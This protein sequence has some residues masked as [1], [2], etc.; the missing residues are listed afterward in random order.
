MNDHSQQDTNRTETYTKT[1]AMEALNKE[2]E[3]RKRLEKALEKERAL[4]HTLIDTLPDHIYVKDSGS[5]F[6]LA[7]DAIV[8]SMAVSTQDEL[9]GKTDFDFHPLEMAEQYYADEQTIL[10]SGQPLINREEPVIDQQTG[11]IRWLLSTKVPFRDGQGNIAGLVGINRDITKRKQAEEALQKL[12]EKLEQ[13]VKDRTAELDALQHLMDQVTNIAEQLGDTSEE[14]TRISAQMAIGSQQTS[15][16][17]SVV[18]SSSQRISQYVGEV[19]VAAEELAASIQEISRAITDVTK[20][21]ANAGS[22]A[23]TAN[24]TISSLK[25]N[26][27]EIGGIIQVITNIAKQTN[28]LALNATLEAARAGDLGKGFRVVADEVRE[29]SEETSISA[30]DIAHKI[31]II[32]T[33]SQEATEAITEV[34]NII[35]RVSELSHTVAAAISEQTQTTSEISRTIAEAAQGSDNISSAISKVTPVAQ[36]SSEQ[37]VSVRDEAQEL[38]SL[39]EQL[40]QLVKGFQV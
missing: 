39:A 9:L 17:V 21:I 20:I 33:G 22:I 36:D 29:L 6:L 19:S 25:T 3:E 4:L 30:K 35:S 32:Q 23:D 24:T 16:Q 18:S 7:N 27:Q 11:A 13:R 34:V 5:R 14:M 10:D 1:E 8:R 26:S 15:L 40:R 2:I 12:N 38:S 37:A 31:Q 28:L